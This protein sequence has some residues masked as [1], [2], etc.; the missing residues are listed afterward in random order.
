MSMDLKKFRES[1][2]K[3][4]PKLVDTMV[5]EVQLSVGQYVYEKMILRT[6]VLTGHARHN[7]RPT[8]NEQVMD[9]QEGVFGGALTGDPI[10]GDERTRW[11]DVK[12]QIK[13]MPIGQTIWISN[14][15]PYI[16]K[17]EHGGYPPGP[18]IVN[19]FSK[20]APNG[21]V[22]IT[23]REVLEGVYSQQTKVMSDDS[24]G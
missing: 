15:A 21:M 1:L 23:L 7:W 5:K 2:E 4:A 19:G 22:M 12:K 11:N 20:K 18:N 3:Q 9:E 17:L 8:I 6:P 24:G 10:T 16:L 13:S 14:N